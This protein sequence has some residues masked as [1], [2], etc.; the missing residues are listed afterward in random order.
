M[1]NLYITHEG[2]TAK[3]PRDGDLDRIKDDIARARN[4]A[5]KHFPHGGPS[6]PLDP[7]QFDLKF[8][9]DRMRVAPVLYDKPF[10]DYIEYRLMWKNTNWGLYSRVTDLYWETIQPFSGKVIR[11]YVPSGNV[12]W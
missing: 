9:G 2:E 6:T 10:E 8:T 3:R 11:L 5:L 12:G 7:P 4:W 1:P